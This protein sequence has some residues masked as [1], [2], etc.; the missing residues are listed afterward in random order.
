MKT[1]VTDSVRGLSQEDV[2]AFVADA[3]SGFDLTGRPAEPNPHRLG[4]Q[5]VPQ[6]LTA[7]VEERA[8]RDGQTSEQ[9]V[10]QA[11]ESYLH[12]A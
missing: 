8:R 10:R 9:V 5:V 7:A 6:D 12:S 4:L 2:A 1:S 3:E 11:L